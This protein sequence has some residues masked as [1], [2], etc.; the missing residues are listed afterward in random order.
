MTWDRAIKKVS[1]AIEEKM[2]GLSEPAKKIVA[3]ALVDASFTSKDDILQRVREEA[4]QNP[5]E[6]QQYFEEALEF[7]KNYN[8]KM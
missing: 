2:S 7:I 3:Y 4:R 5:P 6:K 1:E 8:P